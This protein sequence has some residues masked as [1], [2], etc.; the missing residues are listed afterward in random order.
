MSAAEVINIMRQLP[1]VE[2]QE[3][4]R[5]FSRENTAIKETPS[6]GNKLSP[7]EA[8]DHVFKHYG[9]ILAELAK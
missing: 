7:D 2:R 3:V 8:I 5:F 4:I 9:D 6:A 1:E